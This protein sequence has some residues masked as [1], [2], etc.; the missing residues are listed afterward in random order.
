MLVIDARIAGK[1]K[2]KEGQMDLR[3]TITRERVLNLSEAELLEAIKAHFKLEDWDSYSLSLDWRDSGFNQG[4]NVVL[5]LTM[6]NNEPPAFHT[7]V[8]GD[9]LTAIALRYLGDAKLYTRL[10]ELNAELRDPNHL[11]PGHHLRLR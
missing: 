1:M 2:N 4:L 7:V 3:E 8:E 5:Q 10:V 11:L 9:T 6:R